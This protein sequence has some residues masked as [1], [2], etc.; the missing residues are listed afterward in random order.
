MSPFDVQM[1]CPHALYHEHHV[2]I[3]SGM[4]AIYSTLHLYFNSVS[5]SISS[6]F[7]NASHHPHNSLA[8][9]CNI[10]DN[11]IKK[12]MQLAQQKPIRY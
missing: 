2:N 6:A 11:I 4:A 1:S 10:I 5:Q 9:C 3:Q 8:I 12:G 7:T